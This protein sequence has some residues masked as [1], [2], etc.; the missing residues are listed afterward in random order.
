MS[1]HTIRSRAMTTTAAVREPAWLP[2]V[3]LARPDHWAKNALMLPGI[4]VALSYRPDGPLLDQ[5]AAVALTLVATCVV[6]SSNYV[7]NEVLDAAT[8]RVHPHK[9]AR[10]AAAGTVNTG[11]ALVEWITLCAI[12]LALAFSVNTMVGA[13]AA[14]LWVM[15]LLYN[16]PPIR[17]KDWAYL[18]VLSESANNALRLGLGWFPIIADRFPPI[19]LVIAY[20]MAGAFLMAIKRFSEFRE[21]NAHGVAAAYRRSFQVYTEERLLVSSVFYATLGSV[22]GGMFV[23]R[24]RLELVLLAP[25]VAGLFAHYV[26]IA[27]KPQ[28]A[29]QHPERLYRERK[30]SAYLVVCLAAFVVLMFVEL[31]PLYE[32]FTVE[33]AGIT[34][35][36]RVP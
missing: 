19:S 33:P 18:D 13:T 30:L 7:L 6:A 27:Y 26:Q 34:P 22:F 15:G 25:L 36:W 35:L 10:P 14:V 28:S 29:A 24:Y 3:R 9:S 8:D 11:W 12:G 5:A 31:R 32:W 17:L 4:A 23:L 21:L 1:T 20:W 16:V 2:Y